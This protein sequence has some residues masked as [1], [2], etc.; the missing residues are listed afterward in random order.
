MQKIKKKIFVFCN[1]R[2][3]IMELKQKLIALSCWREVYILI[4]MLI[5]VFLHLITF[6]FLLF[7][8][9]YICFKWHIY[10]Y[11]KGSDTSPQVVMSLPWSPEMTA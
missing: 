9:T 5:L 4:N 6:I 1:G 2:V 7:V 3:F 10:W 8:Y 11:T